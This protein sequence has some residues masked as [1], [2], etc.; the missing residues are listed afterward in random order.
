MLFLCF[1]S[2]F[3]SLDI[4]QRSCNGRIFQILSRSP[5]TP[6]MLPLS[7]FPVSTQLDSHKILPLA[8]DSHKIAPP[9]LPPRP[10]PLANPQN[11]YHVCFIPICLV[12]L[13]S[14]RRKLGNKSLRH[15]DE[16]Y[17]S[18]Y[19]NS[20]RWKRETANNKRRLFWSRNPKNHN[21]LLVAETH[22]NERMD[23]ICTQRGR[24][25]GDNKYIYE[26]ITPC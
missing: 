21:D 5:L 17:V 12:Y 3:F 22:Q 10:A 18:V 9:K 24:G 25:A 4:K 11:E 19:L 1:L 2:V 6:K 8:G 16:L 13:T 26:P 14:P 23:L 20:P 7:I 15:T